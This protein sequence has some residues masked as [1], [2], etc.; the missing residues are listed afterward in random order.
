M[1]PH[2]RCPLCGTADAHTVGNTPA[3]CVLQAFYDE[4]CVGAVQEA[5]AVMR[6]HVARLAATL[7]HGNNTRSRPEKLFSFDLA[8]P[9]RP[10]FKVEA[11]VIAAPARGEHHA[12]VNLALAWRA[13]NADPLDWVD[14]ETDSLWTPFFDGPFDEGEVEM[15]CAVKL[16]RFMILENP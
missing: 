16:A 13:H 4:L 10:G 1:Q 7:D 9:N 11:A 8:S 2:W 12:S 15:W 3:G 14:E 5:A 6:P